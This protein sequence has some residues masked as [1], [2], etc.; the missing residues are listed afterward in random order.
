MH[1]HFLDGGTDIAGTGLAACAIMRIHFD[2][3]V[4]SYMTRDLEVARVD[5][6]VEDLAR[7]MQARGISGLPILDA[8]GHIVGVVTRTDLIQLG[9]MQGGRRPTQHKMIFPRRRASDV[10][11][12][13]AACVSS[14]ASLRHAGRMMID[15][16]IHRVFVTEGREL[17][18]VICAVDLTAAVRDAR[19][20]TPVA[21][22]MTSPIV[23]IDIHQPLSAA[24]DMLDRFH[25]T[26]LIVTDDGHP[27]G[28]FT[29]ANALASRDLPRATPV[30]TVY[31]A[32]VICLPAEMKLHRVAAH[33]ADLRA[34]RVVVCKAREPI[35]I[36]SATDF[37]RVVALS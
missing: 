1:G 21:Q 22:V 19:I 13:G 30:E 20:E 2:E 35:G 27:I 37:A 34:R 6:P 8:K 17:A 4:V 18:G 25:V 9:V 36:V 15:N 24:V 11:T 12:H 14:S 16:D 5:T 33:V 7:T 29:Q 28:M 31:D 23:T 3:P 32:A 10:M 26:G